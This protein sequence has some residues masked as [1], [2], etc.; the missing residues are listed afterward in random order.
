M[1]H[2]AADG[3]LPQ[4]NNA[5]GQLFR[6]HGVESLPSGD[7]LH[8]PDHG[9]WANA[10]IVREIDNPK[11]LILQLDVRLQLARGRTLIE[12]VGG[13]APDLNAAVTHALNQFVAG[14]FH[15]L[16]AAF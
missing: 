7:W 13:W 16:L 14:A 3:L 10:Q 5:L 2:V 11:A 9:Y 8:F 12:S 4:L 6:A 1:K 15:V